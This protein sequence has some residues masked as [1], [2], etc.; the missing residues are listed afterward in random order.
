MFV[1]FCSLLLSGYV[2][3]LQREHDRLSTRPIFRLAYFHNDTGAGWRI[4]N[5]GLGPARIRGFK[6][7]V[8][9]VPQKPVENFSEV[10]QNAFHL[11]AQA[12]I[13]FLNP[14]AGSILPAG[15]PDEALAWLPPGPDADKI[16]A[17]QKRIS[18]EVCYCSIYDEC[19][20]LK[21]IS[22][23]P[24]LGVPDNSCSSFSKDPASVWWRH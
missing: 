2:A 23:A 10:I 15:L 6:V 24:A 12:N 11:D 16:E 3:Y 7:F 18:F 17:G 1:A 13:T 21:N 14:W 4:V 20:L 22:E 8:D 5:S 19:W 9:D